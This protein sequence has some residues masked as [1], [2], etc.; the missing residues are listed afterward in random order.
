MPHSSTVAFMEYWRGLHT[1]AEVPLR[2]RFDPARLKH[3]MP[4]MLMLSAV[5]PRHRFRL[6]GGLVNALH[7]RNLKDAAFLDRFPAAPADTVAASIGLACRR[8]QPLVITASALWRPAL[9]PIPAEDGNLFRDEVIDLEICLCPLG[10]HEGKL[11]RLVGLYQPLSRLPRPL[12]GRLSLYRL[13]GARL[14]D[15][16]GGIRMPHLQLITLEGKRIA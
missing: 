10:N 16:C 9:T 4:Q 11:D 1:G 12:N 6:S 8:A 5:E 3:L 13:T 14:H 7:G 2:S 15:A